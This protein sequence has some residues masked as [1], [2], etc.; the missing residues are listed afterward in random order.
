MKRR[1]C[2]VI[3]EALELAAQVLGAGWMQSRD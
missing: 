1:H 2:F 3:Q